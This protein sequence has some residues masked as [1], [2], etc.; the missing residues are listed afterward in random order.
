MLDTVH[1]PEMIILHNVIVVKS[2]EMVSR[3]PLWIAGTEKWKVQVSR[4]TQG[5]T[6]ELAVW[7]SET[8][9]MCTSVQGLF[10]GGSIVQTL[11]ENAIRIACRVAVIKHDAIFLMI[12]G[13]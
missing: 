6:E 9:L 8:L 10:G 4:T 7:L 5:N 1:G 12:V 13:K 2:K 11:V 3:C